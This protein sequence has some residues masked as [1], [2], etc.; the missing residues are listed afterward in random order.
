MLIVNNNG[1]SKEHLLDSH[2]KI[3]HA[4]REAIDLIQKNRPHG[5]N[6]TDQESARKARSLYEAR[7]KTLRTMATKFETEW[8]ELVDM[9]RIIY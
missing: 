1:D 4:L 6:F 2:F 5:R 9:N 3:S 8:E 7:I